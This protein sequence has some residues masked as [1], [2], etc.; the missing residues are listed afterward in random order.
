MT[1]HPTDLRHDISPE[2]S[3]RMQQCFEAL[4][5]PEP[6][7]VIRAQQRENRRFAFVCVFF[8]VFFAWIAANAYHKANAD[9]LEFNRLR[10]MEQEQSQ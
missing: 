9:L 2:Q 5:P 10:A 6:P 1:L 4:E 8:L 3:A 7:H